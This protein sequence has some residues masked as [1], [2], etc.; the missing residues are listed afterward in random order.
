MSIIGVDPGVHG[1]FALYDYRA[2][3]LETRDM[4]TWQM[5]VNK[6]KRD[7]VDPIAVL[8]YFELAKLYGVELCIIEAVGGRPGQAN[9]FAFGYSVGLVYMACV[10]ARIAIEAVA[11]Q[12]WKK[13]MKVPGKKGGVKSEKDDAILSRACE[14]FPDYTSGFY[15][16]SG[17]K[18]VD[19]AEA[20][21]LAKYG[22]DYALRIADTKLADWQTA[23]R[24]SA[25]AP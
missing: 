10:A 18:R 20:A 2:G 19:R 14:L 16:P 1:A 15:G 13:L 22:A 8:E 4:P 17:G 21:L 25:S 9:M 3:T 6:K 12:T 11:P 7:R 23:L 24:E 5:T